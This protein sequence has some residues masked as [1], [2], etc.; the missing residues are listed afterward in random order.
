MSWACL[1]TRA[2][3]SQILASE[4]W[5]NSENI[6][7]VAWDRDTQRLRIMLAGV[8]AVVQTD[9]LGQPQMMVTPATMEVPVTE[10]EAARF[11][12]VLTAP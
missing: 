9:P 6:T 12:R 5:F 3:S 10:D 11:I 1:S 8:A 2:D 4:Q 7:S